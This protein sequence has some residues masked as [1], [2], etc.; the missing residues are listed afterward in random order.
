MLNEE[1]EWVQFPH[2]NHS[3]KT[4]WWGFNLVA[5]EGH[6]KQN[7]VQYSP[8]HYLGTFYPMQRYIDRKWHIGTSFD[9]T[10]SNENG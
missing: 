10:T 6:F 5:I 7:R 8:M 4:R 1:S 3:P 2:S 9:F